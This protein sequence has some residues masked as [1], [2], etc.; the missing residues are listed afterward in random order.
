MHK[1]LEEGMTHNPENGS[2]S[3]EAAKLAEKN[4]R[5]PTATFSLCR[6]LL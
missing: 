1:L 5:D 6:L 4:N 2:Y 3:R